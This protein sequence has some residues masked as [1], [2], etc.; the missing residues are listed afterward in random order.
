MW[1]YFFLAIAF[2]YVGVALLRLYGH[3]KRHR[4]DAEID[5]LLITLLNEEK[6]NHEKKASRPV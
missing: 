4:S 6:G 1:M 3:K 2:A 5:Q